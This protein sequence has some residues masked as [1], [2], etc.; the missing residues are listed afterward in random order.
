MPE[1][2][3][4]A[5]GLVKKFPKRARPALDGV[6]LTV[7]PGDIVAVV[8]HN[9]AGK[10]TLFD[11]IGGLARPTSGTVAINI[12][13][14]DIG[15]CPQREIVDWSLTVRQNIALG[16]ELRRPA[17][18]RQ[19]RAAVDSVAEALGLQSH[20]DKTAETLSGGE[21]R[22]TQIG[23]AMAGA[24]ELMI[25]DEP[26]TG[27]DPEGI[28]V[29]FRHLDERRQQGAAALISTH[30]TSRFSRHCTRVV[31]INEGQVLADLPADAYLALA[32]QPTEDLWDVYKQLKDSTR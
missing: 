12:D 22:R 27:L 23:R 9:G 21:L 31:A 14:A 28:E 29:V 11:L 1:P 20:L 15:W 26:T 8:G 3:V 4:A 18:R 19:S 25:L 16:L 10:S 13:R 6:D 17:L 7:Y 2:I 32:P 24:P 5:T 30:E